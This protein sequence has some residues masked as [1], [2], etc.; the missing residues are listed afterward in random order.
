MKEI[1]SNKPEIKVDLLES[2]EEAMFELPLED[3]AFSPIL[4]PEHSESW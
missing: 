4:N 2:I 3:D 1:L